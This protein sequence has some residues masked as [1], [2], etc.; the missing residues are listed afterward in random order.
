MGEH[1]AAVTEDAQPQVAPL[2]YEA[3]RGHRNGLAGGQV[4]CGREPGEAAP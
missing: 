3:V 2:S 1:L 4:I